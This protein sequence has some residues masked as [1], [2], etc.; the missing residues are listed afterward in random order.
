MPSLLNL[1][2]TL[3]NELQVLIGKQ[4]SASTVKAKAKTKKEGGISNRGKKK[5]EL[6]IEEEFLI[7][8]QLA[9]LDVS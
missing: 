5:K 1:K 6:T 2:Q 7:L 4:R 3:I 8:Q 9:E